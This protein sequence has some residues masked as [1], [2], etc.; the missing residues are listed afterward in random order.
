MK[1]HSYDRIY[2]SQEYLSSLGNIQYRSL[3]GS[4][5]L[6]IQDTV[7]AM[8]A[9]GE[10]YL[11]ACEQSVQY[12]VKHSPVWLTFMKRGRPVM[13]NYYQV[14]ES[15]WRDQQQLI[16][17]S[18]FS[19]DAALQEKLRRGAQRRLKD[20]PNMTF[21]LES[22]LNEVGIND[23][24]TL[25]ILGAKMCWLRLKQLNK[26][27]TDKILYILEGAIYGVHEAALPAT[28]RRELAEWVK[29]LAQEP[30]Y[31]LKIE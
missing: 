16:R 30:M 12:C 25:R 19:L 18:K 14:D 6:T 24:S 4:Y 22:L 1:V 31:P 13:L 2:K 17:L 7:F 20:L 29:S 3:F 15:L 8:V 26:S 5:S 21:H 11:R 27:I 23:V 9:D 28:R 10:L